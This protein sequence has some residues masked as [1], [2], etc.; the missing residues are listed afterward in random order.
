MTSRALAGTIHRR[1]SIL[2]VLAALAVGCASSPMPS[3]TIIAPSAA[4]SEALSW[5]IEA[6]L[7]ERRWTTIGHRPG[8]VE[9]HVRSNGTG[10]YV[11]VEISYGAGIVTIRPVKWSIDRPRYTRWVNLL[12]ADI[13]KNLAQ[14]GMGRGGPPAPAASDP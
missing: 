13:R 2:G 11:R 10:E 9:A 4:S 6:G 7:A 12:S 3:T 8:V 5:A 14:I 1:L